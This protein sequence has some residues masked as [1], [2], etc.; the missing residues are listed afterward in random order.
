LLAFIANSSHAI[1][2]LLA[3]CYHDVVA[4]EYALN[5]DP[6]AVS[7]DMLVQH[8]SWLNANGYET[9]TLSEWQTGKNLPEKPLM[10]TFDDGYKS[11]RDQVLPLLE[12][13]HFD[14]VIAPVTR[15]V[16][17]PV[18]KQVVY[19]SELRAREDFLNWQDMRDILATKRVEIASHTHNMHKGH[20]ANRYKSSLPAAA[21]HQ[22]LEDTDKYE[23]SEHYVERI[24][25]DLALSQTLFE[26]ELGITAKAIA[27]PYGAYNKVANSVAQELGMTS[28]FT[29][30][31]RANRV[32]QPTIHR[33]LVSSATDVQSLA[34]ASTNRP[35]PT[36]V[37]SAHIDLDYIFDVD[38]VQFENNLNALLD[39]IESMRIT[40]VFLQAFADPDGDGVAE[41]LYFENRHLPVRSDIFN[42]VAWQ[43]RTRAGVN[44][45]AWMPVLAFRLPDDQLNNRLAV[46]SLDGSHNDRYHRLSPFEVEAKRII[47]EIYYDLGRSASFT[48]VLFHD[49]A[50]LTDREDT[51]PEALGLTAV[52]KTQL[53]I[54][55]T[56]ELE[57][58][59]RAWQPDLRTARNLYAEVVLNP[60][61]EQWFAQN[62]LAFT[63]AYDFT[64]V[65]AMPYLERAKSPQKWLR[66]L[67][68]KIKQHGQDRFDR[69]IFHVQTRDWWQKKNLKPRALRRQFDLLLRNGVKH[70]AYYPDDFVNN[71]P[72]VA[73]V[74]SRLSV[75]TFPAL[76]E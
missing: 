3:L 48:G 44:V 14:A 76:K 65:M 72:P 26:A 60:Q 41:S 67:V 1:E 70:I 56:S 75:N 16:N 33:V 19:G 62:Y 63:D 37:R 45:Y 32:G 64:A 38:P 36:L 11:F 39:R 22:W 47:K 29:L 55:F 21:S 15:W 59:L 57:A 5:E 71:H 50:F 58:T 43:L 31:N 53:L 7:L 66:K 54:D 8:F 68:R 9:V 24:R 6:N 42:R 40:T 49:D 73:L 35:T 2:P 52:E 74:R 61:S 23:T 34:I 51:R 25:K 4:T 69:T 27:W 30:D 46:S 13:F 28:H 20:I 18:D 17:T 10:I 12:L